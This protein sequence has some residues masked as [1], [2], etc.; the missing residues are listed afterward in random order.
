MWIDVSGACRAQ[1]P[2][3]SLSWPK[4]AGRA[5][6][7]PDR[8]VSHRLL[9]WPVGSRDQYGA[10]P[11]IARGSSGADQPQH[12]AN[13]GRQSAGVPGRRRS[14][15]SAAPVTTPRRD[16]TPSRSRSRTGRLLC[17]PPPQSSDCI[18]PPAVLDF[19]EETQDR[20]PIVLCRLREL[21]L[22]D[23]D[24]RPAQPGLGRNIL[25]P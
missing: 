7:G 11:G 23:L 12:W 16:D 22:G 14:A 17:A 24:L 5:V 21:S 6:G 2:S 13:I 10:K 20:G 18:L 1:T 15:S 25:E 8:F 9:H 3:C 19:L 4:R